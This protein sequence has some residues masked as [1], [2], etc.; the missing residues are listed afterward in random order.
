[1]TERGKEADGHSGGSAVSSANNTNAPI[2]FSAPLPCVARLLFSVYVALIEAFR[3]KIKASGN[4]PP[5]SRLIRAH[6]NGTAVGKGD[7]SVRLQPQ[8]S[9]TSKTKTFC[10]QNKDRRIIHKFE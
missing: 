7:F 2:H 9:H 6:Q 4:A 8:L 1:M 10:P 3:H 5:R